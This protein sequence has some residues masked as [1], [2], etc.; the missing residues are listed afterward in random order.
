MKRRTPVV[1][2]IVGLMGALI[3]SEAR[4]GTPS[5]IKSKA[6]QPPRKVVVGTVIYNVFQRPRELDAQLKELSTLVDEMAS[7]ASSKYPDRGLDLAILTEESIALPRTPANPQGAVPLDGPVRQTFSALAR[8]HHSYIIIPLDLAETASGQPFSTNAAVLFDRKGEVVGTY[9]KV[10]PVAGLGTDALEG[11]ITPGKEVPVFDCDFGK[12]GIQICWDMVFDDGW[13]ILGKKGAEIVAWV[14]NSPSTAQPA[15]R[16]GRHR[17][18]IVS[19]TP[20]D[21]ATI[22]EPTGFIG[23]QILSPSKIL[24]H[25]IDLSYAVLG[26]SPPLHDGKALTEKFGDRVGYHY[27]HSEDLGMFWSND[28]KM[29]IGSMIRTLGLE[30]IDPQIERNRRLQD[31]ARHGPVDQP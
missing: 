18:Y 12:L 1:G 23:P 5:E 22:F 7:Q 26:W 20:R 17:Y 10:H 28:P 29:T 2:L 9:R 8:K 24:V 31:A 6:D 30:E 11:G 19:S 3:V 4:A 15:S 25:E 14:S 21:N 13:D 27:G 16:A